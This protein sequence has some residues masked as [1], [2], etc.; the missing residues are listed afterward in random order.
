MS[1]LTS[2][3][4]HIKRSTTRVRAPPGGVSILSFGPGGFGATFDQVGSDEVHYNGT[5]CHISQ[6]EENNP[7]L[8]Q[9]IQSCN[10]RKASANNLDSL[11][12]ELSGS[13]KLGI[14]N[15]DQYDSYIDNT[16]RKSSNVSFD[17]SMSNPTLYTYG[18]KIKAPITS[19]KRDQ[20]WEKKRR[21]WLSRSGS[22]LKE[23]IVDRDHMPSQAEE[24]CYSKGRGREPQE[25]TSP[26][27]KLMC[28][29]S[30][31]QTKGPL[32][33]QHS[34]RMQVDNQDHASFHHADTGSSQVKCTSYNQ[35]RQEAATSRVSCLGTRAASRQPPGG[36]S[37]WNPYC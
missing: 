33:Q 5:S 23:I 4:L 36:H 2:S 34:T 20:N 10:V 17:S 3:D 8:R 14:S 18:S 6:I 19:S 31:L 7:A 27:S 25:V 13:S 24:F 26:L 35:M 29:H 15:R 1:T 28:D 11:H 9:P 12:S 37:N 32:H 21:L 22:L 30:Q 16:M